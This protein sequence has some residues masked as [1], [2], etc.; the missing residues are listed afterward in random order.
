MMSIENSF[1]NQNRSF[2]ENHTRVKQEYSK[3]HHVRFPFGETYASLITNALRPTEEEFKT[4]CAL[5]T[6][7]ATSQISSVSQCT[8]DESL[9]SYQPISE[10]KTKAEDN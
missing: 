4:L 9:I 3:R 7:A 2:R 5:F 8:I 1:G 10:T 6:K